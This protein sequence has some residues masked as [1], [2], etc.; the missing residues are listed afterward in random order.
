MPDTAKHKNEDAS[1]AAPAYEK[2]SDI[3]D[4]WLL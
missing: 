4:I 1:G 3:F 2:H